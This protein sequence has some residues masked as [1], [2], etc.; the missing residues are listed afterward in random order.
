MLISTF[1]MVSAVAIHNQ[2]AAVIAERQTFILTVIKRICCSQSNFCMDKNALK[3][4]T[5]VICTV[6]HWNEVKMN[7]NPRWIG[8]YSSY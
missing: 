2:E 1:H 8:T 6:C 7:S 5:N 4:A 3:R